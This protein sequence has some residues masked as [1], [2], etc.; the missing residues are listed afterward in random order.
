MPSFWRWRSCWCVVFNFIHGVLID[1][2]RKNEE[3]RGLTT[4]LIWK[5][6]VRTLLA[7]SASEICV[8]LSS[9]SSHYIDRMASYRRKYTDLYGRRRHVYLR[10]KCRRRRCP[11][12]YR[13][14]STQM[15]FSH[16]GSQE[17]IIKAPLA[18]ATFELCGDYGSA[19][20]F[21]LYSI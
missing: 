15:L 16:S 2:R 19:G 1:A 12:R 20:T 6:L 14:H 13:K 3:K 7:H 9:S 8:S 17:A 5:K 4:L 10:F 11:G 18:T 21:L